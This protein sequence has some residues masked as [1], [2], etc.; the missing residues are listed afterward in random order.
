MLLLEIIFTFMKIGALSFGGAYAS[1][2][3]VERQVVEISQWMT[4]TEFSDL[5]ALDE[6]TPGPMLINSA[7]FVGMKIAGIPGAIAA[8]LGCITIPCIITIILVTIYRKYSRID[9]IGDA[10]FALKSMATAMVIS[11]TLSII[12]NAVFP[13]KLLYI[14][15]INYLMIIMIICS[16]FILR[17]YQV[18]P[19]YIML[20]CGA[21]NL[22][23]TFLI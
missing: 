11:T 13:G 21:L 20:G 5:M 16:F 1:I 12:I 17:K 9:V 3:L 4:Y 23:F 19:I 8:T 22:L 10:L 2:P 7:T 14:S 15:N 6:L 18:N